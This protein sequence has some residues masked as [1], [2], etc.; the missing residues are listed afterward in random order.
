MATD[1]PLR[2][3]L[4]NK[5]FSIR[6]GADT[7]FFET[8]NL[9]KRK[10]HQV[11]PFSV[12]NPDNLDSEFCRY[13]G[14]PAP[15]RVSRTA[16]P[17]GKMRAFWQSIYNTQVMHSLGRLITDYRPDI[18]H[19][20]NIHYELTP[21]IFQPLR[22]AGIPIA[23][24][25]HDFRIVCPNGYM[26]TKRQICDRCVGQ[27]YWNAVRY[28]CIRNSIQGSLLGSI[29][30]YVYHFLDVW[31]GVDLFITPSEFLGQTML[32]LTDIERDKIVCIPNFIDLLSDETSIATEVKDYFVFAGYLVPQKGILT[33]VEAMKRVQK[34][35]LKIV[36]TGPLENEIRDRVKLSGLSNI[37]LAGFMS[38][39]DLCQLVK[40]AIAVVVP[41]EW[42]ENSPMVIYES[43]AAGTPVIASAIGG[44]PEL[45]E[46]GQ[47]GYLFSPGDTSQLVD[48]LQ[49][50]F[51]NRLLARSM[52]IA[53]YYL[54]QEK[55]NAEVHYKRLRSAYELAMARSTL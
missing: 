39:S 24:T 50:L 2:V 3:L 13:F 21:A 54:W 7:V 25:L 26:Y 55:F 9:L 45:V 12:K 32:G 46:D 33:L 40:Q 23:M 10:G 15:W 22:R 28:R 19:I 30:A 35:H 49:T 44:I 27:R 31:N 51:S 43:Y 5:Y 6:G 48:R 29:A 18:A 4:A 20:H 16:S 14:P 36:G 17:L 53:G 42:Y 1:S 34:A 11:V 47:T 52:G 37:E 8:M 38:R 41:S